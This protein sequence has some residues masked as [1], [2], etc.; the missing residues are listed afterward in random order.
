MREY[1]QKYQEHDQKNI[2][3]MTGGESNLVYIE[4]MMIFWI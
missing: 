4:K 1:I 3:L 2:R